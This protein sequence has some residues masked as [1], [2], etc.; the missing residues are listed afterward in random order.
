MLNSMDLAVSQFN[1]TNDSVI[2]LMHW[3]NRKNVKIVKNGSTI[4]FTQKNLFHVI[5]N[6]PWNILYSRGTLIIRM[7]NFIKQKLILC[8]IEAICLLHIY[9]TCV[10]LISYV[11]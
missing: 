9:K 1:D 5:K 8:C 4:F 6:I 10:N 11:R 3:N 7:H 2:L